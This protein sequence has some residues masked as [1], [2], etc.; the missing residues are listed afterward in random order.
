MDAVV[1]GVAIG[2][3]LIALDK[4]GMRDY[5]DFRW[6]VAMVSLNLMVNI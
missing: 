2:I 4:E 3:F 6:W 5:T 1:K